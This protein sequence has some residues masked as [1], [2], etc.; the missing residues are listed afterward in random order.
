M[1][2][3]IMKV[4]LNGF[5]EKI[6]VKGDPDK[7]ILLF[8]HGGPGV[9]NR[10][11][12]TVYNQDLLQDFMVV[13]WDQRGT[14][15]SYWGSDTETFTIKQLTDDASALVDYLCATYHKDKI[16]AIGG[17][18]GSLLGI[19]LA[20]AHPEHLYAFV[21]FGQ[22][23]DGELNEKISYEYALTQAQA[24]GDQKAVDKLVKLGPPVMACYKGGYDGMMIQREIMNKYGGYSQKNQPKSY[25]GGLAKAYLF[26]G[27]YSLAD[28]LGVLLGNRKILTKMWPEVGRVKLE[29]ECT[30]FAIPI[31]IF[32]GCL[33]QNT[34]A[35]LVEDYFDK[36]KAPYKELIWY[37]ESGHNPLMDEPEL[38]KAN[39]KDR[40]AKVL[41]GDL[42]S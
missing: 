15:G 41:K 34:P 27:E 17:S 8:I 39:L 30:E 21:G 20:Y 4:E 14:G 13:G 3:K 12:C 36:I 38:F 16:F 42:K 25:T 2:D 24:A 35:E 26:S 32:D 28:T 11:M 9:A 22:F 5:K 10:H 37:K 18:W 6:H 29:Q 19:K 33:D 7:S 40:L 1:I 31:F 23:V